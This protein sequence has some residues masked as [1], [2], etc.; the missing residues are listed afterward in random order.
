MTQEL[1]TPAEA[2]AAV[3]AAERIESG[4]AVIKNNLWDAHEAA[5]DGQP[6]SYLA[7]IISGKREGPYRPTSG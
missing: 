3:E 6:K 2:E 7:E 4:D 5:M 1:R